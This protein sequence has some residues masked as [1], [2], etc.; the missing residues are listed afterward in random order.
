M[1]PTTNGNQWNAGMKKHFGVDGRNELLP[2]VLVTVD[3]LSGSDVPEDLLQ[4]G[5]T[6]GWG[7]SPRRG[8]SKPIT[9]H[10]LGPGLHASHGR[11]SSTGIGRP[12]AAQSGQI[13]IAPGSSLR[14]KISSAGSVHTKVRNRGLDKNPSHVLAACALANPAMAKRSV[15][16]SSP[17]QCVRGAPIA[18]VNNTSGRA[19]TKYPGI[20]A[21]TS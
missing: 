2:P 19:S 12:P 3:S 1:H 13:H 15:L 17:A 14:F 9:A 20:S 16:R 10:P 18:P 7:D 21:P 4:G 6:R 5:E 11:S 8:Q